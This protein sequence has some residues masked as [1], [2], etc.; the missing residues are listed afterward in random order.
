MLTYLGAEPTD[1]ALAKDGENSWRYALNFEGLVAVLALI[2]YSRAWAY[3]ARNHIFFNGAFLGFP[4]MWAHQWLACLH[5]FSLIS[6]HDHH[7]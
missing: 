6:I 4:A 5:L 3:A 7:S 2:F 1:V